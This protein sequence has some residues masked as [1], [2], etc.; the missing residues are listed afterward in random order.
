M[1]RLFFIIS[2][3]V[4]NSIYAETVK[5]SFSSKQKNENTIEFPNNQGIVFN[6]T[7]SNTFTSNVGLF[8]SSECTGTMEINAKGQINKQFITCKGIAKN[9]FLFGL[10]MM[11][12]EEIWMQR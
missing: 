12:L 11:I 6:W 5:I 2:F 8:G 3:F 1:G 10:F 4:I 9:D 7:S